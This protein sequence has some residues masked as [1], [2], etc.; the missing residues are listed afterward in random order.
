MGNRSNAVTAPTPAPLKSPEP[1]QSELALSIGPM[2]AR[3]VSIAIVTDHFDDT[4]AALERV[5][6][7]F[8]GMVGSFDVSGE[9]P[10]PRSIRATLK[11]P[12]DR[13]DSALA[14]IRKLGK[15]RQ[16]SQSSED[17]GDAHRDLV[18]RISNAKREETRLLDIL[19]RRTNRLSDVLE[20]ER[21]ASRVRGEIERME[22][23]ELSMRNRVSYSTVSVAID[24]AYRAEL[25]VAE[26][27]L[28]R[29]LRNAL[30]DGWRSAT[31]TLVA[32]ILSMLVSGPTLFVWL[33]ILALPAWVVWRLV[34]RARTGSDLELRHRGN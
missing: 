8:K 27:P 18:V 1:I 28:G 34:R 33:L 29:R 5:T 21:E 6:T 19:S 24:E 20:V 22:A 25:T 10:A 4:R 31:E 16:E 7:T 9:P 13:L 23:Q 12:A 26:Q 3:T 32:A 2:I 15:V 17:I 11:I 14:D 30:V